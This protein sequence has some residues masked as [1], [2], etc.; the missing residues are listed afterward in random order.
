[1]K[2]TVM[3]VTTVHWPDDTRIRERLM[4][5]LQEDF[6]VVYVCKSPGPT[7]RSGSTT[8]LLE[9]GR[10]RRNLG[11]L[12]VAARTDCDLVVIHDPELIPLGLLVRLARRKPVVFDVHENIPATALTRAW[13]PN[14]LRKPLASFLG[15]LLHMVERPFRITLA[16]PAYQRLFGSQHPVFANYPNTASY[17]DPVPVGNGEAVYLGDVTWGR[18]V[19][20]AVE[21]CSRI[22]VPLTVIGRVSKDTEKGLAGAKMV[23]VMPNPQAIETVATCSVGLV[24]LRD[25][26]NYRDSQPTKMLEYLAV[27][28]PVVASDLP[29]TRTLVE[30]LEAVELVAPGDPDALAEAISRA[31]A[32]E[33]RLAAA[34]QVDE[35]RSR[36]VW[37]AAEVSEFYSSLV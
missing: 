27:G 13:V 18:G 4:R 33:V 23:G 31:M 7:D 35:I 20:V 15:W 10:V 19:D 3:V 8:V 12:R 34:R 29:G 26:P 30:G 22:D 32:P 1:M 28:V 11:A 2:P 17:P 16:E 37:P 6:D 14:W 36:F 9:G 24:P 25:E 21:A 5:T